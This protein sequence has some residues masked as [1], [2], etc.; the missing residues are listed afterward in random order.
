[1]VVWL[2]RW[3]QAVLL[4]VAVLVALLLGR[5][6]SHALF[7]FLMAVLLALLLNPLVKGLNRV[8]V[9]RVAAVPLVY[10]SFVAVLVVLLVVGVPILLRQLQAI[11]DSIPGWGRSLEAGVTRLQDYLDARSI[12][13]DVA[14]GLGQMV[15]WLET[16]SVQSAGALLNAGLGV[17]GSLGTLLVIIIASFYMLIDGARIHRYLCR[18]LPADEQVVDRYLHGLQASFTRYVKGQAMVGV[19][20]AVLAGAGLWAFGVL[21]VWPE[22]LQYVL[23]LAVW[24]GAMELIPYVGP[25]IGGTPPVVLAF[26]H[27]PMTAVWV[28]I[29]FVVLQQIE[30]HVLVPSIMGST[31]GVHPLV[32]IFV[33]L[34]AFQVAGIVGMLAV[35][36][37]LAMV[38]HTIDFFDFKLSRA[39]WVAEDR[40]PPTG[41]AVLPDEEGCPPPTPAPAEQS[42]PSPDRGPLP[43]PLEEAESPTI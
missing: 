30:G 14:A 5:A 10:L 1:V 40:G 28:L 16:H 26:F 27:S 36:P 42:A 31:V 7:A 13:V 6:M 33:L 34:A 9:P 35:L 21:G 4:P 3:A 25:W 43:G 41:P 18:V 12:P 39:R 20:M 24:A 29:L 2:P 11:V 8:R 17:A 19:T 15:G 22:A 32:V 37:L 23:L 38:K